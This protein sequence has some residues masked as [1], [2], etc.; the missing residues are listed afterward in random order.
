MNKSNLII[1]TK[2]KN[3]STIQYG[4]EDFNISVSDK[5][6]SCSEILLNKNFYLI[7]KDIK[8]ILGYK[9]FLINFFR[10]RWSLL[11]EFK[12]LF[13]STTNSPYKF[14]FPTADLNPVYGLQLS[15]EKKELFKFYTIRIVNQEVL[16]ISLIFFYILSTFKRKDY[17]TK[18]IVCINT[19][20][21]I[22]IKSLQKFFPKSKIYIRFYDSLDSGYIN[23]NAFK[24][25]LQYTFNT[26]I[27]VET[28]SLIDSK[29]YKINYSPN[30]VN[31]SNLNKFQNKYSLSNR[32]SIFFLG[33]VNRERLKS[34]LQVINILTK[35][36]VKICFYLLLDKTIND[37]DTINQINTALGYQ[38]IIILKKHINYNEY[39]KLLSQH[40]IIIDFYRF[41]SDEGYSFRI[42]EAIILNKKIITNRQIIKYESFYNPQNVLLIE[43]DQNGN[44]SFC[45][46]NLQIFLSTL[47][48][49]YTQSDVNLFSSE[50]YL[51]SHN[52]N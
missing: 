23:I 20:N 36:N 27:S 52:M 51:I 30:T 34:L 11:S 2:N 26:N 38:A 3:I 47:L 10:K 48:P 6:P 46:D 7:K 32:N 40:N 49:E 9:L 31:I 21:L 44:I 17:R 14:I 41:N 22:F 28:Y 15:S 1:L 8:S 16:K 4:Y 45:K 37:I 25:L 35:N 33:S 29:K 42:P 43:K 24:K 39:I 50:Q 12:R 13:L 19:T 18:T 5:I